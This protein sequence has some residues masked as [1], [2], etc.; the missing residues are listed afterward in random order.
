MVVVYCVR[1]TVWDEA[2]SSRSRKRRRRSGDDACEAVKP[3][4]ETGSRKSQ[5]D[6]LVFFVL[7]EIKKRE[8]G[9]RVIISTR[10]YVG[11][12]CAEDGEGG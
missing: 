12:A 4:D 1:H 8:K 7:S 6:G 5:R 3:P 9:E 2:A 11:P 10:E